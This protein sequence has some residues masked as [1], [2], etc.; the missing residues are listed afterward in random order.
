MI[1]YWNKAILHLE[2]KKENIYGVE[3]ERS[4]NKNTQKQ[5][6]EKEN[7]DNLYGLE[8]QGNDSLLFIRK[9]NIF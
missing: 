5:R 3:K 1:K 6:G 8:L 2:N 7:I 4:P 9:I